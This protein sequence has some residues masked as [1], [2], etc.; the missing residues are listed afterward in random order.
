MNDAHIIK[1]KE[2]NK[3]PPKQIDSQQQGHHQWRQHP[4]LKKCSPKM[5]PLGRYTI[6][7]LSSQHG[8]ILGFHPGED[9]ISIQCLQ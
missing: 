2:K 7:I 1:I 5:T 8:H 9:L 6:I 3:D 4:D